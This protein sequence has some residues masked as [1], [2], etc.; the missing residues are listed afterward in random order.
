M[1]QSYESLTYTNQYKR[2]RNIALFTLFICVVV[3]APT[4]W[5]WDQSI[6]ERQ[7][8]RDAKNVVLNMNYLGIEYLGLG[9]DIS[10]YTRKSGMSKSMEDEVMSY[11]GAEGQAYL[12]SW[13]TSRNCVAA[14]SY[15]KGKFLIEYQ[16]D[17]ASDTDSWTIYWR[18]HIYDNEE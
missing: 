14:M 11:S 6:Q 10:D 4:L 13:N 7:I 16:Y 9:K 1:R 15:Q 18:H 5:I 2:A 17:A 8:L 3:L 12:I